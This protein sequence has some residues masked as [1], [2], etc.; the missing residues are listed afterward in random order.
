MIE[1]NDDIYSTEVKLDDCSLE[2][3]V[4]DDRIAFKLFV[5]L[6]IDD[7]VLWLIELFLWFTVSFEYFV[8]L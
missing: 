3:L 8:R 1:L 7:K 2:F 5:N 4:G 6:C